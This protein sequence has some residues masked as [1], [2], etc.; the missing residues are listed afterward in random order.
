MDVA[1]KGEL[2]P[3]ALVQLGAGEEVYCESGLLVYSDPSIQF[4]LR[5]LTQGGIS[6]AITRTLFGGVPFHMHTYTGPGYAAFSRSRPGEVRQ[7]DLAAGQTIDVSEHSLLLASNTVQYG[8]YYVRGTGRIGRMIGFWMDRL[9][10]PGKIVYQGHGN[11]LSFNL[12]E[13]ETMDVD[14]GALLL[15]DPSV[16][17]EAYNQPLGGGLVGHALSFEALHVT[18][19]G[20]LL[21]QTL[22]PTRAGPSG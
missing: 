21:L 22:D 8:T 2:I 6:G 12:K 9:T 10:G 14:H 19:P 13:K 17:V 7:I 1:I 16:T 3:V 5:F 20:Q 15:K 11:I 4:Q 18:G